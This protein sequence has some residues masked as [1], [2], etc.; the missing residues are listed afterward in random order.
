MTNIRILFEKLDGVTPNERRKGNIKPGYEHINVYMIFDILT[1]VICLSQHLC[2]P[3]EG[4]HEEVYRIFR[5]LQKNLGNNLG[6]MAYNTM[7]EPTD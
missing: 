5:Y 7:Y 6:S 1:E 3:R 4:H 2:S